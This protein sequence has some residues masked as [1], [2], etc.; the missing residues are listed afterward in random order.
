VKEVSLIEYYNRFRTDDLTLAY[1]GSFNDSITEKI[2]DLSESFLDRN[3]LG[4]LKRKTVFLVAE[5]FQNV[6]RH[7]KENKV[8]S[9]DLSIENA[10]FMRL[11]NDQLHIASANPIPNE[12][13]GFLTERIE[14]LN[15]LSKDD[16]YKLYKSVLAEGTFSDKGGAS[17]GLIEMARKTGHDLNFHFEPH[18]KDQS[19]FYLMLSL[20]S[21]ELGISDNSKKK[22]FDEIIQLDKELFQSN[23]YI[24]LKS[25]FSQE[26]I[27]PVIQMI[28]NNLKESDS[29]YLLKRKILHASVE[30]MQNIGRHG[31]I[32]NG[33]KTGIFSFGSN[34]SD[35]SVNSIHEVNDICHEYLTKLFKTLKAKSKAELKSLYREKLKSKTESESDLSFIDL[36]RISKKWDFDLSSNH[37]N[38]NIFDFHILL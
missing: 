36:T 4:S 2:I 31:I 20:K 34:E 37:D 14:Y 13:I 3:K 23:R 18:T 33:K 32:K 8:I 9:K 29:S 6:A 30:M 1:F 27:L 17:L 24:L 38:S 25:D 26:T 16:L 19:V 21:S 12:K 10:F 7:G 35:F 11:Q 22:I 28:E 15:K 5:C